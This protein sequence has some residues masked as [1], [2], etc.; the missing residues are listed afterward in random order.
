MTSLT[1]SLRDG[2]DAYLE[3]NGFST[4]AY[5]DKFV[6]FKFGPI[7]LAF[8]S[9]K[10]RR[11][12]I[13]FHDLHH[14]LTGYQATPIGEGEIGAWEVAT[15]CRNLWAG[16]VLNLFAMGFAMPFASRRVY[17]AFV[18]GRHSRNLY[19]SEYTEE[20][21]ATGI[22]EMRGKLGLSEEVPKATGADKRAFVFWLA[23]SAG[24][25]A[26]LALSVLG[27]LALLIWWIWL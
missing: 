5:T 18:R 24:Q 17:R 3:A 27:P 21:L 11:A 22:D 16:W 6:H 2:R 12:A 7:Y 25:Y 19:G 9:T 14:V 4:A 26:A 8:P 13:P 23:L 20:L 15:G 10:T 1:T